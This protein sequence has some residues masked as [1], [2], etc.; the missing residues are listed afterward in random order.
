MK[1]HVEVGREHGHKKK[2]QSPARQG[3]DG[4]DQDADATEHL[5][6]AAHIHELEVRRQVRWHDRYVE[7]RIHEVVGARHYEERAEAEQR[8][9]PREPLGKLEHAIGCR[10][11]FR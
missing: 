7:V 2:D 9:F 11:R 5:E 1:S 6:D 10:H 8:E 3:A 4:G